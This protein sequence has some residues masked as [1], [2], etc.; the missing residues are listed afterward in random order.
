M[1]A[2]NDI[3]F[4]YTPGRRVLDG[5]S[6][7]FAP[8]KLTV[9]LGPNGAGKTTL[10]RILL[11]INRPQG[12][13]V[14]LGGEAIDKLLPAL[15]ARRIAYIPQRSDMLFPFTV[16]DVVAMAAPRGERGRGITRDAIDRLGLAEKA[17]SVFQSLSAGQQQRVVV[18]RALAQLGD[19]EA[20]ER[21][22]LA[23]EPVA[24]MD[25]RYAVGVMRIL[26]KLAGSGMTVVTVLHD[27][28][29][30]ATWCHEALLLSDAGK[31]HA[32]GP[33]VSALTAGTLSELYGTPL[34][35]KGM[36][37]TGT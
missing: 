20:G 3:S 37:V 10:L 23:D 6:H 7:A 14:T 1:L 31:V 22:L 25:P 15:R 29:L 11:G 24:A 26:V 12:G 28:Q 13:K 17:D 30:A 32:S 33:V 2:A 16:R 8:G 21:V 9:I 34:N 4:G 36:P 27:L 5:V 19:G 35:A 18:A